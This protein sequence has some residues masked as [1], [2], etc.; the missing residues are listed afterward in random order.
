MFQET[1][2]FTYIFLGCEISVRPTGTQ[3]RSLLCTWELFFWPTCSSST[4]DRMWRIILDRNLQGNR[5]LVSFARLFGVLVGQSHKHN[6]EDGSWGGAGRKA[7]GDKAFKCWW[8]KK[9]KENSCILGQLLL[10][11]LRL[12]FK[13]A[14]NSLNMYNFVYSPLFCFPPFAFLLTYNCKSAQQNANCRLNSRHAL[15]LL[16]SNFAVSSDIAGTHSH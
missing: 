15:Q 12:S 11:R 4:L 10:L 8:K 2:H 9:R 6:N 5:L 16:G 14:S 7:G 3:S 13:W 1:K